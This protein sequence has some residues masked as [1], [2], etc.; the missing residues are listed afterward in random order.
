M[1]HVKGYSLHLRAG[2]LP[3]K[4]GDTGEREHGKRKEAEGG[5]G[6][7]LKNTRIRGRE[8]VEESAKPTEDERQT[9]RVWFQGN[10]EAGKM[11]VFSAASAIDV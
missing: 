7:D 3:D 11:K 6:H 5:K 4:V 10:K 8:E 9:G 2:L 1:A